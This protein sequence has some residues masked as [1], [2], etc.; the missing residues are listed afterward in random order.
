MCVKV[1]LENLNS[2]PYPLHPTSTYIFRMTTTL[3]VRSGQPI[4]KLITE[5]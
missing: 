2:D 5:E 3:R 1:P 4:I